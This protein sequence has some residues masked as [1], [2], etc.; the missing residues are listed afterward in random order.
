[1]GQ[2]NKINGNIRKLKLTQNRL[3]TL[4]ILIIDATYCTLNTILQCSVLLQCC[5]VRLE[6]V[7]TLITLSIHPALPIIIPYLIG[8]VFPPWFSRRTNMVLV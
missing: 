2:R 6:A 4:N 7:K 8:N 5:S 3:E 1:M